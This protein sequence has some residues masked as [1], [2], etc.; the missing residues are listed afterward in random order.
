MVFA[1]RVGFIPAVFEQ[2]CSR[3]MMAALEWL[4]FASHV[5]WGI[6]QGARRMVILKP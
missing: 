4:F 6:L 3:I 5:C 2:A 1:L